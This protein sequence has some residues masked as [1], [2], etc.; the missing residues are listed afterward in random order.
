MTEAKHLGA[1]LRP[2]GIGRP[3]IEPPCMVPLR[4]A[5]GAFTGNCLSLC[6]SDAQAAHLDGTHPMN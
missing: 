2:T 5:M 4:T 1:F 3:S 6:V